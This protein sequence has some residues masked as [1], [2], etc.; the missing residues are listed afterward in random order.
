M[1]VLR[2]IC[3]TTCAG[4]D[5]TVL[6]Q[7]DR[8]KELKANS[9]DAQGPGPTSTLTCPGGDDDGTPSALGYPPFDCGSVTTTAMGSSY[10]LTPADSCSCSTDQSSS[11]VMWCYFECDSSS[12]CSCYMMYGDACSSGCK[13][14][15]T[16]APGTSCGIPAGVPLVAMDADG[17]EVLGSNDAIPAAYTPGNGD[18]TTDWVVSPIMCSSSSDC[19]VSGG[20]WCWGQFGLQ[21]CSTCSALGCNNGYCS[22][23]GYTMC[24]SSSQ[25]G[26]SAECLGGDGPQ[27]CGTCEKTLCTGYDAT[28]ESND[29]YVGFVPG[30]C[31]CNKDDPDTGF[32]DG[33]QTV[34]CPSTFEY[35]QPLTGC[36]VGAM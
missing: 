8:I 22:C 33:Q 3:G 24:W 28:L 11:P 6:L 34:I 23:S 19:S 14:T 26:S 30:V 9:T 15:S 10:T 2:G 21:S 12:C 29:D 20:T 36:S 35:G 13:F 1:C 5:H 7:R 18:W 25:C 27:T 32:D 31:Y 17:D 4:D 16:L